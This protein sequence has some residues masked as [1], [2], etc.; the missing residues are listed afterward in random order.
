MATT[1]TAQRCRENM[2]TLDNGVPSKLVL[3]ILRETER[4]TSR[5]VDAVGG[6]EEESGIDWVSS[7]EERS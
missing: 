5:P 1:R 4:G 3:P 7:G 6:K 2:H